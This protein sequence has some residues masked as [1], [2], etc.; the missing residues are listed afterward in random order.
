[1]RRGEAK[2][3]NSD[4]DGLETT[5]ANTAVTSLQVHRQYVPK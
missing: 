1:M 5:Q 2:E 3:T 4:M